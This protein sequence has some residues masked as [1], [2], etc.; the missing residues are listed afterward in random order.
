MTEV[1][2]FGQCCTDNNTPLTTQDSYLC[3]RL[4]HFVQQFQRGHFKQGQ[5]VV[6][7]YLLGVHIYVKDGKNRKVD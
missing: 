2:R 4:Y 6:Y 1:V 3:E 7:Q 5:F